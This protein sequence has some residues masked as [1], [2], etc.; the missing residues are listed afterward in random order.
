MRV[1]ARARFVRRA[2]TSSPVAGGTRSCSQEPWALLMQLAFSKALHL[3]LLLLDSN[4]RCGVDHV[5]S[6]RVGAAAVA[7]ATT[8][9]LA[10]AGMRLSSMTSAVTRR[11]SARGRTMP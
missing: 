7:A 9:S 2:C 8:S 3:A 5:C 1:G 4:D 10:S 6:S 11:A